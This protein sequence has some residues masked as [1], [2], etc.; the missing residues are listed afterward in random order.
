MNIK[1]TIEKIPGGMMVLPLITAALINTFFPKVL[2]IGGFTTALFK[3]GAMALIGMFLVC[4][5]SEINFKAAPKVLVR[6]GTLLISKYIISVVIGL[7]V[8]KFF[9]TSGLFG[10]SSLAIIAAMSN[11]NG[12]LYAALTGESGDKTDVGAIAIISLNDGPFLTM[13]AMG[14]AG[15]ANIPVIYLIAVVIPILVGMILGNLDPDIRKFLSSAG[16]VLIPF[17]AF[18]LGASLDFRMLISSGM[19]GILLGLMTVFVGGVFN[20]L[21]DRS[22]GGSGVA[23]AAVSSTAGN[24]VATPMAVAMAD[25]SLM[26]IAATATAQVAASTMVTAVLTPILTLYIAK[27]NKKRRESDMLKE[28]PNQN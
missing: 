27:R 17:F 9:G 24:A 25:P 13:L 11:S 23:G 22:T 26:A 28:N 5:G 21:A 18:A 19:P 15:L 3:N 14:S 2:D 7:C 6:G 12:G 4:M 16:P 10:L 1:R 20:I 8:G